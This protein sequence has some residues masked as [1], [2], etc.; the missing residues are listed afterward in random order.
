MSTAPPIWRRHGLEIAVIS[1]EDQDPTSQSW[2]R[3]EARD[4]G[5]KSVLG[6]ELRPELGQM[7][8]KWFGRFGKERW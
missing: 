7:T 1:E 8:N 6:E 2:G 4:Y 3:S 5:E